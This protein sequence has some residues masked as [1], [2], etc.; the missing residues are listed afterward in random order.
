MLGIKGIA[1]NWKKKTLKDEADSVKVKLA[2]RSFSNYENVGI[3]TGSPA[4]CDHGGRLDDEE[5]YSN[6]SQLQLTKGRPQQA[7]SRGC[8]LHL[9]SLGHAD[10]PQYDARVGPQERRRGNRQSRGPA[11]RG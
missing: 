4:C 8:P 9:Q 3:F 7:G 5:R 10:P 6:S 11:P 2:F 1:H